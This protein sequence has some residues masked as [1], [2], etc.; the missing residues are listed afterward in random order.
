MCGRFSLATPQAGLFDEFGPTEPPFDLRPRW[1][2]A[3]TQ[4]VA[5]L[6]RGEAVARLRMARWGLVPR[7][8]KDPAI[9]NRMINAR[10]ET[11]ATK[12][13]FRRAFARGRCL[14]PADGWY[15]WMKEGR[16]RTPMR[17]RLHGERPFAFAGLYER[18]HAGDAAPL[19]TCAIV[20]TDAAPG[21]RDI[22]DRMPAVLPPDARARWLDRAA[23]PDELQA[24]LRP[25]AGADLEAYAVSTLVNAPANDAP[26]C[27]VAA[28]AYGPPRDGTPEGGGDEPGGG[29][30]AGGTWV[31][32]ELL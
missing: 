22:H 32:E 13:A 27:F 4:D 26:E 23:T 12:P 17:L 25:Y 18:W 30:G 29:A 7:W 14:V 3:P 2:I 9:G 5:V 24:L 11:L 15:E 6:L 19:L 28:E 21:I 1:N 10:A 8:A 16:R 31:Q 20:T